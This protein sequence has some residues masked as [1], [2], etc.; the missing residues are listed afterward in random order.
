[1]PVS[2]TKEGAVLVVA[3]ELPRGNAINW[4]F[5]RLLGEALDGAVASGEVRVL[6]ITGQ[7]RV[8]S[9]GLDLVD[10]YGFDRAEMARFVDAFDDLFVR[11]FAFPKPV[12]AAINGHAIAGGAILAMAADFRVMAP[13]PF[14]IGITEVKLGI[15]F[16]A[17]AF[18]V[19]RHAVPL[20]ALAEWFLEGRRFSPEEAQKDGVV[21]RLAGEGGALQDVIE[22]AKLLAA[23]PPEAVRA[24]K[25]AL[26]APV[27]RR[28]EETKIESRAR[29]LDQWFSP[30]ARSSV[31]AVRDELLRRKP[32]QG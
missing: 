8:F 1:M 29:F 15:P 23:P 32:P 3:L 13:G 10:V 9:T 20:A 21:H 26:R 2:L 30:A 19:A 16:P 18:E 25:E 12:L 6:V 22:K 5:I 11:I 24:V 27:L 31:A 17:G 4:E 7:G 28:I 14:Q